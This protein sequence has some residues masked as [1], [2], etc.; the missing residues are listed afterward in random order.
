MA[1]GERP[2]VDICPEE[3]SQ[4]YARLVQQNFEDD[5][6]VESYTIPHQDKYEDETRRD[7]DKTHNH[8]NGKAK[9]KAKAKGKGKDKDKD[10][11]SQ[12]K[13]SQSTPHEAMGRL[14]VR[15]NVTLDSMDDDE[16]LTIPHNLPAIGC[17]LLEFTNALSEHLV[18][19]W[20]FVSVL[21]P[22][23]SVFL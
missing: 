1:W 18:H 13:N 12:A 20:P 22:F 15:I 16:D 10:K 9:A 4:S 21:F 6:T 17:I 2:L 5:G 14:L 3:F 11:T 7:K 8:T 19:T 23:V